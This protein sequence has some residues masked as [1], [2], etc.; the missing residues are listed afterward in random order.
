M[1]KKSLAVLLVLAMLLGLFPATALAD[2]P[3]TEEPPQTVETAESETFTVDT[4]DANLADNDELFTQYLQE[5]LYPSP[6]MSLFANF[7]ETAL[8][9]LDLAVYNDLKSFAESVAGGSQS[10]TQNHTFELNTLDSTLQQQA[11][12]KYADLGIEGSFEKSASDDAEPTADEKAVGTRFAATFD[13]RTI[14]NHLLADCPDTFYWY[15]KTYQDKDNNIGALRYSYGYSYSDDAQTVTITSLTF[16]FVVAKDYRNSGSLYEVNNSKIQAAQAA[17]ANVNGILDKYRGQ[18]TYDI[19]K[20]YKDEICG[21]VEYDTESANDKQTPYGDPWQII[22]VFDGD[23]STNVVCEGYAKAFQYL[24]SQTNFSDG[25]ACYTVTG[26][27][28]VT[29]DGG[30]AGDSGDVATGGGHM[31]NIIRTNGQS[32][33]VDVTNCDGEDGASSVAVGY[34]DKLFLKVPDAGGSVLDGYTFTIDQQKVTYRYDNGI[35]TAEGASTPNI[36]GMYGEAILTL[37]G[38][39]YPLPG[40]SLSYTAPGSL[41]VGTDIG[42]MAPSVSGGSGNY[43]YELDSSSTLPAGLNLGS[44][45]VISGTP[46]TATESPTSV[47]IKVTD[48]GGRTGTYTITFPAVGKGSQTAVTPA[49]TAS[50]ASSITVTVVSGQKYQIKK[51]SEPAPGA[52]D[53]GWQDSFAGTFSDLEP[54]T[55]YTV[56][57]YLPGNQ[58]YNDSPVLSTKQSTGKAVISGTVS[59]DGQAVYGQTLTANVSGITPEAAQADLTYQWKA[60]NVEI[61]GATDSTYQLTA[62]EVGK[63][64]SV[65]VTAGGNY[66]GG[67]TSADTAAVIK[68]TAAGPFQASYSVYY[69]D[70]NPQTVAISD[71]ALPADI[72]GAS[73]KGTVGAKTDSNSVIQVYSNDSFTLASNLDVGKVNSTASWT[74]TIESDN[75]ADITATVTVTVVDMVVDWSGVDALFN[76]KTLTYGDKESDVGTLPASGTATINNESKTGTFSY[77]NSG[78]VP[79]AGTASIEVQF[80]LTEDPAKTATKSYSV[81]VNPA[82]STLVVSAPTGVTYGDSTVTPGVT[83]NTSNAEVTYTYSQSADGTYGPWSAANSAGT[84]YVKGTTE[85]TGNYKAAESAPVRFEVAKATL[86]V[87]GTASASA[88]YGTKLSQIQITGLSVKLNGKEVSGSW[89][90]SGDTILDAGNTTAY[91]AVFTPDTGAENYNSLTQNIAPTI[92]KIAWTGGKTATGSA[93]YG[94]T[95]TVNLSALIAPGGTASYGSKT[96]TDVILVGDPSVSGN[97]LSFTFVN[98]SGKA[99]KSAEIVV[100]VNNATNYNDYSITVTVTVLNK[101]PQSNFK[102]AAATQTRTYGDADFTVTA[103]GAVSGSTVSYTSSATEVA[104]VDSGTGKVHILKAGTTT[105]TATASATGDYAEATARYELTVSKATVTVKAVDQSIYVNGTVPDLTNP[106]KGT[107]YTV[108]GLVGSDELTGTLAMTY[109][110]DG[111][112]VTPDASKAGTY[113]IVISGVSAPAGDNYNTIV[114]EKGTLTIAE[115]STTPVTPVEPVV[116]STPSTSRDDDDDDDGDYSVSVPSSTSVEGGSIS[117]SPRSADKGDTVSITVRPKTGYVLDKL[118]VTTRTGAQVELARK[119]ETR[120]TFIM[121]AGSISVQVSFI[122]EEQAAEMDFAD[123]PESF[124]AVNEIQWAYDNGFMNGTSAVSFNPGGTVNRQQVWMI[125]ARMAGAD[126]AS[127]AEAK[128]WAVANGISDG[129]TP[130]GAVTRQQLVALLYRFAV[131]NGY[132]VSGKAD[133]SIYPDAASVAA[134]ASDAMSWAVANGIIGGTTAG[135]LNP[136]GD[137]NRAQL[138]VILWRFYQTTAG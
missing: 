82:D 41:T 78:N 89:A 124:W 55:E 85:A 108:T 105:I 117:V 21:L 3:G 121:P 63:A 131:Q 7:G 97:T 14:I 102:F 12:W 95:G 64:I 6:T 31:W 119:S 104:T 20:G 74:V 11:T 93:K 17:L 118:T 32:Y 4:S 22:S 126:P 5:L 37:A 112:D 86:S 9:G 79:N 45:G 72:S 47:T 56:Y 136:A 38:S 87:D 109:Q 115:K 70:T 94:T 68:A 62:A 50:D 40:L 100:N 29:G 48:D 116:P 53:S 58:N 88:N 80:A 25:T 28:E 43:T 36:I 13:I 18:S 19:L 106:V 73:F 10:S 125:L 67:V 52:S 76:G 81:T 49:I 57:T 60:G 15:D 96:D 132:D 101:Q 23:E 99:N 1:R 65:T 8:T 120:Y 129:T 84:W 26:D 103:S 30:T 66:N 44:D 46:T 123:V 137:S 128:A 34:P 33:L 83:T 77:V 127:M 27:M 135:T 59:I 110:K 61:S 92:N 130:T 42:A 39:D 91:P 16:S 75:Y 133:L 2:E 90:F 113:D 98:D 134:Y 69:G 107:H 51:S 111:S 71:F 35:P 54:N 122:P 24:C 114:I 138:A